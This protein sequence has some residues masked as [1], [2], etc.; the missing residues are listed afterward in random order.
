MNLPIPLSVPP[1]FNSIP[2][3]KDNILDDIRTD[4]R[5]ENSGKGVGSPAGLAISRGDSDGRA[6]RHCCRQVAGRC[7]REVGDQS[8]R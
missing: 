6:R 2:K 5:G 7:R 4:W 3:H 8:L 1:T